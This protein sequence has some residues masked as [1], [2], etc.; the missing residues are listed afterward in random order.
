[1][2][3]LTRPRHARRRPRLRRMS[4]LDIT[5]AVLGLAFLAMLLFPMAEMLRRV[6]VVDGEL[7]ASIVADALG[8]PSLPTY[9]WQTALTIIPASL[10]AVGIA[11]V[12]AWLN[13][14]TDAAMGLT[15]RLLPVVPL[16]LPPIA[17]S[18]GWFFL[19]HPRAGSVNLAIQAVAGRL[20]IDRWA[21][22]GPIN[23]TTWPGLVFVYV[24]YL[25]PFGYLLISA[26]YRNFDP[27]MEE[28]SR[29]MG[30]GP[31]RTF[32]R[33]SVPGILPGI[34]A[35]T[36]VVGIAAIS[37]FSIPVTIGTAA[38]VNVLSV[39]I[40]RLAR[41]T[42]PPRIGEAVVLGLIVLVVVAF[43][44][45]LQ[46]MVGARQRH[47]VV[48]GRG[49]AATKVALGPWRWVARAVMIG[50][51]L[52]ASVLPLLA[53]FVTSLQRFWSPQINW[54]TLNFSVYRDLFEGSSM[55]ADGL[56]NSV[57]LGIVG[58]TTA[59]LIAVVLMSYVKSRATAFS[60]VVDGGTK[61]P[62]AISHVVIGLAFVVALSG[63]PFHLNGTMAILLLAYIVMYMPQASI[64]AASGLDQIGKDLGEASIV[65]G[66]SRHRTLARITLPLIRSS[67][68]SGWA[69]LFVVMCGDLTASALLATGSNPVVGFVIYDIWG[70]ATYSLLAAAATVIGTVSFLIVGTILTWGGRTSAYRGAKQPPVGAGAA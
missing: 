29:V 11:T 59:M 2:A 50:Y 48:G 63:S 35:G 56:R 39:L 70:N 62:G 51:L 64:A 28:A 32:I 4:A 43:L 69:L 31:W 66:S 65:S 38:N 3:V 60:R 47:S 40:V 33:V 27:S 24:L 7:Q 20:G 36:F 49:R 67:V 1:M 61:L 19:A 53:L 13:E 21:D 57:T 44:W 46:R 18:T 58:A 5:S 41:D 23:I 22:G 42:Y 26:A 54:N 30:A 12:F 25:V 17:L 10:V 52:S 8:D 55:M 68:A 6:F 16:L 14:R 45:I 37:S 9:L 34:T 15:S